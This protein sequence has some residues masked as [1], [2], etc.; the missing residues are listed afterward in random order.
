MIRSNLGFRIP[1]NFTRTESRAQLWYR[2]FAR[3]KIFDSHESNSLHIDGTYRPKSIYNNLLCKKKTKYVCANCR[4][5]ILNKFRIRKQIVLCI[6]SQDYALWLS[7]VWNRGRCRFN[8]HI[9]YR[10]V[11]S[12][13][14]II[15]THAYHYEIFSKI[16]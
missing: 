14:S 7:F 13:R 16:F 15:S 8:L 12:V 3:I 6:F 11:Q 2:G 10:R 1:H 9:Y 5:N 4:G